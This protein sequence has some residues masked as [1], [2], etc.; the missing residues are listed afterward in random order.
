MQVKKTDII[1]WT[2][3]KIISPTNR[4]YVGKTYNLEKRSMHYRLNLCKSQTLLYRSLVKYGWDA[5]KLEIIEKINSTQSFVN[6]KEIFWIRSNMSN[7]SK[8][9]EMRG[10]N[11]TDG[12]E[13][14]IGRKMS[15]EQRKAHSAFMKANP[16]KR[17]YTN[18]SQETLEKMS[19]RRKILFASG[20]V[21]PMQ[22]TKRPPET[23][24]RMSEAQKGKP[25]PHRGMKHS[26]QTKE[27]MRQA[28]LNRWRKQKSS[29]DLNYTV[30]NFQRRIFK[31]VD[32]KQKIA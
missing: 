28:A 3:Y 7:Y 12:G 17:N 29:V 22:G 20:W 1:D 21:H 15:D 5:H 2:V 8:W 26:E 11:L 23:L 32:I 25:S 13:G 6:G 30:Y 27:N 16:V 9:P 24:K 18:H 10:L 14:S 19:N 4:V 31:R